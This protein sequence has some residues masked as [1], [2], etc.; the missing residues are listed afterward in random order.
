MAT[1]PT[2]KAIKAVW[3]ME[4]PRLIGGLVRVVHDVDL[5]EDLAQEALVTAATCW[6]SDEARV[7]FKRAAVMTQNT[8]ERDLLLARA[9][10]CRS[11]EA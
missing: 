5:A 9:N 10:A 6:S 7:E 8:R 1:Q 2:R 11:V 3:R 4:S